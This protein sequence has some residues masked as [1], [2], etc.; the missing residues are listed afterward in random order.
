MCVY[1]FM[2]VQMCVNVSHLLPTRARFCF[3]LTRSSFVCIHC[4][5]IKICTL[6]SLTCVISALSVY[7]TVHTRFARVCVYV[8]AHT[9]FARVC[10]RV[11]QYE[12]LLLLVCVDC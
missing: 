1:V 6:A 2:N 8:F 3:L 10:V 11:S 4:V 9:R 5:C 12:N 7:E